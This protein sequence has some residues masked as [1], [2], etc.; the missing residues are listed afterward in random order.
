MSGREICSGRASPSAAVV[1]SG[2]LLDDGQPFYFGVRDE[3]AARDL[4]EPQFAG[5]DE[6]VERCASDTEAMAGLVNAV[7]PLS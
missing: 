5:F 4:D 2:D 3:T 1:V 6:G 7:G